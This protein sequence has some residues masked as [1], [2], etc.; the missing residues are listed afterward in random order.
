M[1]KTLIISAI[2]FASMSHTAFAGTTG[3][4][5]GGSGIRK[6]DAAMAA[7]HG[8]VPSYDKPRGHDSELN[9]RQY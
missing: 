6:G 4:D 2:A 8:T 5:L 9:P 7:S 3:T 1:C